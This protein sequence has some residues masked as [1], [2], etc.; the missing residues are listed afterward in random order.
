MAYQTYII[1]TEPARRTSVRIDCAPG[2]NADD[3]MIEWLGEDDETVI[4]YREHEKECESEKGV[5]PDAFTEF[6]AD[7]S[8]DDVQVFEETLHVPAGKK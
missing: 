3:A 1:V 5:W 7:S 4:A 6:Y 8:G 2:Q